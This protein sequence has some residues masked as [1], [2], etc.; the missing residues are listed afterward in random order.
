MTDL[1]IKVHQAC[2]ASLMAKIAEIEDAILDVSASM[3]NET[4][5][6]LG[7]KHETSRARMQAAQEQLS[8]QLAELN[9]QLSEL[10]RLGTVEGSDN[11][12]PGSLVQT[13][14]GYLFLSPPV[15]SGW[16]VLKFLR[17]L[18]SRLLASC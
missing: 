8:K 3:E 7:D 11:T 16:R 1:K 12:F 9:T 10:D 4:K 2:R 18:R 5:S 13:N 14:Q 6:S 15:R 17:S